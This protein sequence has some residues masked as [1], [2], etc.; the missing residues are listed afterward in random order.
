MTAIAVP[1]AVA[2]GT[3]LPTL[4]YTV[5]LVDLIKY[6][7]AA[8]DFTG[9]HWNRRIARGVGLP[10]VIA[11][12]SLNVARAIRAVTDWT[13][14]PTSVLGYQVRFARPLVVPDD[15][16]GVTVW[17]TGT[18]SET[19]DAHRIVVDLDVRS[20]TQQI[21]TGMRVTVRMFEVEG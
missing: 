4:E 19:L 13:G 14:D 20:G 16:H 10:D 21:L 17:V 5:R 2:V 3:S 15:E 8:S 1:G 9:I 6:C 18:V 12:G 7:G 11:H